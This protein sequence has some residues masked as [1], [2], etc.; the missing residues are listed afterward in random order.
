M[1]SDLQ[2]FHPNVLL[3]QESESGFVRRGGQMK[4]KETEPV[5]LSS[6]TGSVE[7]LM[8]RG[9]YLIENQKGLWQGLTF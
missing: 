1:F 3:F 6:L 8:R 9:S 5:R 7:K 2:E 4:T